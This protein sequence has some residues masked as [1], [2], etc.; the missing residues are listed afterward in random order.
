MFNCSPE[1]QQ[2]LD[3]VVSN[4]TAAPAPVLLLQHPSQVTRRREGMSSG[5]ENVRGDSAFQR[6]GTPPGRNL[7]SAVPVISPQCRPCSG[8]CSRNNLVFARRCISADRTATDR[9]C[10]A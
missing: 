4:P 10:R 9:A 6:T 1:T 3:T 8:S 5:P 2:W 7:I